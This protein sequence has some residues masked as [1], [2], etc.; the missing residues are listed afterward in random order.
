[1]LERDFNNYIKQPRRAMIFTI[2]FIEMWM[3]TA[4]S[5]TELTESFLYEIFEY[6]DAA[7]EH[8]KFTR[9]LQM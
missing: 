5:S 6:Y 8:L 3:T 7:A 9:H 4:C 1:M 2:T